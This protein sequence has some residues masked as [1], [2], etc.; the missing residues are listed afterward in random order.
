MPETHSKKSETSKPESRLRLF[1][2]ATA[3]L[4]LAVIALLAFALYPSLITLINGQPFGRRLTGINSP[5]SSSELAAINNAPDSYFETAGKMLLN[6]S[7]HGESLRNGTYAGTVFVS[8][9][10]SYPPL[11]IDGKPSI[12]YIGA[13]SCIYCGENRWA[14]ALALSRFGNFTALYK[15]YSALGDGDVPTLFWSIENITSEGSA[16]YGNHYRS[17]YVNFIS[18]EYDSP[19]SGG[20][21]FVQSSSPIDYFIAHAPNS[22]YSSAMSFMNST[23]SFAGTPFTFW[24]VALNSGADAVVF[25]TP[26]SGQSTSLPPL[27]YMTHGQIIGQL[28]N[29][30]TTFAT[31]E[32]AAADVYV[33]EVCPAVN[34]TAPVCSLPAIKALDALM[35]LA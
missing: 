28:K 24:G 27:S 1:K 22:S 25:G 29:F 17:S 16:T 11:V 21:K 6:L 3:V 32:Y 8:R 14:M 4:S 23:G 30:N 26:V 10:P 33:A 31:Q 13:I 18:A 34:F 7:L 9:M 12:V 20:F 19:I 5:L 35:R 2:A 15:G